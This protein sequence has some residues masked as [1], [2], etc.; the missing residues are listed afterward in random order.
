MALGPVKLICEEDR[1]G[2]AQGRGEKD[3]KA[4]LL[5]GRQHLRCPLHPGRLPEPASLSPAATTISQH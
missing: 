2:G 5:P 1:R 3:S 4:H